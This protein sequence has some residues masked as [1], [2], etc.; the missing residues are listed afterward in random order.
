MTSFL[1]GQT[2]KDEMFSSFGIQKLTGGHEEAPDTQDIN[3]RSP[4]KNI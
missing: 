4:D 1:L 2:Q 3:T